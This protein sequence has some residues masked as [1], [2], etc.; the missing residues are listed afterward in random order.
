[1][2]GGCPNLEL[3]DNDKS[4]MES[5]PSLISATAGRAEAPKLSFSP[6]F[7]V[8]DNVAVPVLQSRPG[9]LSL[10]MLFVT[11]IEFWFWSVRHMKYD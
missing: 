7:G 1:M 4:R 10:S 8:G 6:S 11:W 9:Q 2:T 3:S 5:V